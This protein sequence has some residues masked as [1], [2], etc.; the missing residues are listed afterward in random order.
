MEEETILVTHK[1]KI[2]YEGKHGRE[3]AIQR[4]LRCEVANGVCMDGHYDSVLLDSRVNQPQLPEAD[5]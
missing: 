3:F 5:T 4:A 2:R 1:F